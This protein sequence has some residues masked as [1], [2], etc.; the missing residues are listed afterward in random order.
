[1]K[2]FIDRFAD[3]LMVNTELGRSLKRCH[4][5]LITT[6]YADV[7]D[8]TLASAFSQFASCLEMEQIGQVYVREL[9]PIGAIDSVPS[10]RAELRC[11]DK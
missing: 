2:R 10:I 3:L 1:M 4:C 6:G 11:C 8:S 9:G 5:A 7:P